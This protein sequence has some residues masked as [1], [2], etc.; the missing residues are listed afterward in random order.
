MKLSTSDI[1]K[2]LPKNS[3]M[4]ALDSEKL[5][6]LHSKLLV[7][8]KDI[9]S[10]CEANGLEYTLGGGSCLGAVRH[11]GFIP[12]DDDVDIN[13]TRSSWVK[14][15][16]LFRQ[17]FG[18]KYWICN[19]GE[20]E[21]YDIALPRIGIK[22]TSYRDIAGIF[23]RESGVFV[24]IFLLDNVPD[25]AICRTWHGAVSLGIGF[26]LSCVR[27]ASRKDQYLALAAD[28]DDATRLFSFKAKI[29]RS[30]SFKT[31]EE[32]VMC[33]EKWNSRYRDSTS[34]RITAPTGRKHYFK[35][36]SERSSFFPAKHMAFE[37]LSLPV[38][39]DYS[40]YLTRLYGPSYMEEPPVEARETHVVYEF[41]MGDAV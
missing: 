39:N 29:G 31:A 40:A 1:V 38:P 16:P 12:W 30:L 34:T 21:G 15:E 13:M 22:G 5:A 10:I 23:N 41:D 37:G 24:D 28:N 9:R 26:C 33:W 7:L 32:W 6:Q 27:F 20:T 4:I 35:E 17:A 19:P 11:N 14:F 25:N 36:M 18:D 2:T 3:H 8:L